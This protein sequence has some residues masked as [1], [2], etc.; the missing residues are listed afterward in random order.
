MNLEAHMQ[1]ASPTCCSKPSSASAADERCR[2]AAPVTRSAQRDRH[3]P[4]STPLHVH[5][6]YTSLYHACQNS[7]EAEATPVTWEISL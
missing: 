2:A 7:F 5:D 3:T 4:A 6:A 1:P